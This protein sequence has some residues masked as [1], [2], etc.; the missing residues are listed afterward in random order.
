MRAYRLIAKLCAVILLLIVSLG[1][2]GVSQMI[3]ISE[4]NS[5]YTRVVR[6]EVARMQTLRSLTAG[7]FQV[8]RLCLIA[9]IESD[10]TALKTSEEYAARQLADLASA[11]DG[12]GDSSSAD[13]W[14]FQEL[15]ALAESYRSD[16]AAFFKLLEE[17]READAKEFRLQRL[18]PKIEQINYLLGESASTSNAS[19]TSRIEA[20]TQSSENLGVTGLMFSLW[21]F[22]VI[23]IALAWTAIVSL[24]YLASADLSSE[25]PVR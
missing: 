16:V 4:T 11:M 7:F 2:L 13:A 3:A 22:L 9:L 6:E 12:F 14:E 19:A 5:E 18:R 20:M 25:I 15:K 17:D 24:R 1:I 23:T 8:N 21:P 10:S